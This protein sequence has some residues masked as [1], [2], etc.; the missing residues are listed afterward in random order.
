[1]MNGLPPQTLLPSS[2]NTSD[3][4][5][6][7]ALDWLHEDQ[8]SIYLWMH[9]EE[10]RRY[11]DGVESE[12]ESEDR[13]RDPAMNTPHPP[14]KFQEDREQQGPIASGPESPESP[15]FGS[16]L[17][18]PA[19][20]TP[21][22]PG[23]F[24]E[25][26]EKQRSNGPESPKSPSFGSRAIS[27]FGRSTAFPS[28]HV[29]PVSTVAS[30]APDERA[31]PQL[32][33]S[34]ALANLSLSSGEVSS[35][36][37]H[38]APQ[39][40][41]P[42]SPTEPAGGTWVDDTTD[43]PSHSQFPPVGGAQPFQQSVSP[44]PVH[45]QLQPP[46]EGIPVRQAP[47]QQS[48]SQAPPLRGAHPAQ[49]SVPPQ[50]AG[51]Y[52]QPRFEGVASG[53][54][55]A[56]HSQSTPL[57]EAQPSHSSVTLQPAQIYQPPGAHSQ[58][59]LSLPSPLSG[60]PPHQQYYQQA[61]TQDASWHWE[62]PPPQRTQDDSAPPPPRPPPPPPPRYTFFLP[63]VA[64]ILTWSQLMVAVHGRRGFAR[65][66]RA[67]I[68]LPSSA[69]GAKI[70]SPISPVPKQKYNVIFLV[71]NRTERHTKWH[72]RSPDTKNKAIREGLPG[73]NS[74][75]CLTKAK[76]RGCVKADSLFIRP[77]AAPQPKMHT[78]TGL[79]TRSQNANEDRQLFPG[80][81][82][83]KVNTDNPSLPTYKYSRPWL[84]PSKGRTTW[85]ASKSDYR[86]RVP[87]DL[88][89]EVPYLAD[90]YVHFV[91]GGGQSA[92]CCWVYEQEW[93]DITASCQVKQ[94]VLHPLAELG[95]YLHWT[96]KGRYPSW[97][98]LPP[99][100]R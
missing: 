56:E 98:L 2:G 38:A 29:A 99:S 34:Q 74:T 75:R 33:V 10:T 97:R 96:D 79:S 48:Y 85:Y 93:K 70:A 72:R 23:K 60:G 8:S 73:T 20:N 37:L 62:R 21:H 44:Q 26:R 3:V 18:G 14:G 91:T 89:G 55:Y 6:G 39:L 4:L 13:R 53:Q 5:H 66:L 81:I 41:L 59:T 40:T 83:E 27:I 31:S 68:W 15:S 80:C 67:R 47:P 35:S 49:L 36:Q 64:Q 42:P 76:T 22:P 19:M 95:R 90:L 78:S 87:P 12:S 92:L 82:G 77:Q 24:S 43:Q 94:G 84:K 69:D 54:A 11:H 25:H 32:N 1:M 9:V 65:H 100:R 16:S 45:S 86:L 88:E 51:N 7:A 71:R 17:S 50:P 57:G 61:N 28:K 63:L 58:A 30:G 52:P 46:V